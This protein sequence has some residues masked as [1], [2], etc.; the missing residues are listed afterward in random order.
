M[1]A[2]RSLPSLAH[3]G[4]IAHERETGQTLAY[5][6]PAHCTFFHL[7]DDYRSSRGKLGHGSDIQAPGRNR[8]IAKSKLAVRQCLGKACTLQFNLKQFCRKFMGLKAAI[9][10]LLLQTCLTSAES[11]AH[12]KKQKLSLS[13]G[14]CRRTWSGTTSSHPPSSSGA[15]IP[16]CHVATFDTARGHRAGRD[17]RRS[18]CRRCRYLG[19]T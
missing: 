6:R 19:R 18:P 1:I 2:A 7:I 15:T 4:A 9:L 11:A 5:P 17:E 8:K 13:S 12:L 10:N 16:P 14:G 3:T